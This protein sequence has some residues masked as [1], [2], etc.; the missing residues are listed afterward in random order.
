MQVDGAASA[1]PPAS[2]GL[3]VQPT[4]LQGHPRLACV[5]ALGPSAGLQSSA[6]WQGLSYNYLCALAEIAATPRIGH[7]PQSGRGRGCF[8]G[9]E[10]IGQACR[11]DD[12]LVSAPPTRLIPELCSSWKTPWTGVRGGGWGGGWRWGR[13]RRW[14]MW[15]SGGVC[16]DRRVQL[17][18][19]APEW[20]PMVERGPPC[21]QPPPVMSRV[22]VGTG[23]HKSQADNLGHTG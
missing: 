9:P 21:S 7:W 8:P 18:V 16:A 3:E 14:A 2:S 11:Q 12:G 20:S 1:Q 19:S 22:P 23:K 5:P 4:R 15:G 13:R 6:S 10:N 17:L